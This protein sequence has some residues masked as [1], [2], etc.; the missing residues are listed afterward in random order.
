MGNGADITES[1]YFKLNEGDTLLDS[2]TLITRSD[3]NETAREE[4]T[5][6]Q[7][8]RRGLFKR[9]GGGLSLTTVLRTGDNSFTMDSRWDYDRDL[10]PTLTETV[11]H[12]SS[13]GQTRDFTAGFTFKPPKARL[14]INQLKNP[15]DLTIPCQK[16]WML[17]ID[18]S[19]V[20]AIILLRRYNRRKG[21][22]QSFT[23]IVYSA[24]SEHFGIGRSAIDMRL[25]Q[26]MKAKDNDGTQANL[27]Y[28]IADER[29]IERFKKRGKLRRRFHLWADKKHCLRKAVI[30]YPDQTFTIIRQ[31]E[32]EMARELQPLSQFMKPQEFWDDDD[33]PVP[34]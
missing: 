26:H 7:R 24:T 29:A 14:K 32:E 19:I 6:I 8:R 16:G 13:R 28:I 22:E 12:S 4:F 34:S 1:R 27:D 15:M 5:I 18:P 10:H 2:G 23:W 31:H 33:A 30:D 25:V 20:P 9:K 17:N 11:V 3:G 21:G